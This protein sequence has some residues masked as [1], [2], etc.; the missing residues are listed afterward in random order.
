MNDERLD[1]VIVLF[2]VLGLPRAYLGDAR[3]DLT[4]GVLRAV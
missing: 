3:G 1:T 2:V 4:V